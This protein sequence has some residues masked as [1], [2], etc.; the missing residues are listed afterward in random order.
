MTWLAYLV[1]GAAAVAFGAMC[2]VLW[3]FWK[4]MVDD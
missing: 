2:A 1:V 3:A 4:V